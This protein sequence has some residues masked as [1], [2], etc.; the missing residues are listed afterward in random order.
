MPARPCATSSLS[1][2]LLLSIMPSGEGTGRTARSNLLPD[3]INPPKGN[4]IKVPL[5]FLQFR[6]KMAGERVN[7]INF[8]QLRVLANSKPF[9]DAENYF[10]NC[11]CSSL[12]IQPRALGREA[13]YMYE[14]SPRA[15][16]PTQSNVG[17]VFL[18]RPHT[19]LTSTTGCVSSVLCSSYTRRSL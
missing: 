9:Y 18:S 15:P 2:Y 12:A 4:H 3:K 19:N 10:M 17:L 11:P 8:R 7:T 14:P 5:R 13:R 16:T 6:K 1:L